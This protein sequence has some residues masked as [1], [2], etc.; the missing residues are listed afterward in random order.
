MTRERFSH[1]GLIRAAE[2]ATIWASTGDGENSLC[3]LLATRR[4]PHVVG[5]PVP[6]VRTNSASVVPSSPPGAAAQ[7]ADP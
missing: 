4:S 6:G 3:R 1:V 2:I 7:S 5:D